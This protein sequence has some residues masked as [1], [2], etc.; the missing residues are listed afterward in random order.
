MAPATVSAASASECARKALDA[1]EEA[2]RVVHGNAKLD[3]VCL[4]QRARALA[5]SGNIWEARGCL[6][7]YSRTEGSI[8]IAFA[9]ELAATVRAELD[10]HD[11]RIGADLQNLDYNYWSKQLRGFLL[12]RVKSRDG[13]LTWTETAE[14]LG[15]SRQTLY[16]WVRAGSETERASAE[17]RPR[18]A[19]GLPPP[20]V[21]ESH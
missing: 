13:A 15:I 8:Q 11:F 10:D 16:H 1:I 7:T 19:K 21:E 17:P 2:A 4:L 6:D 14:R 5:L 20:R 12:D 18:S 9:H 3:A